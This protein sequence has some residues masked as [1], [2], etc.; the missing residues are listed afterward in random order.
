MESVTRQE[1][2]SFEGIMPEGTYLLVDDEWIKYDGSTSIRKLFYRAL[3]AQRVG[4]SSFYVYGYSDVI[5]RREPVR[6]VYTSK[7][8]TLELK[9]TAINDVPVSELPNVIILE[10]KE[11]KVTNKPA[12]PKQAFG[13]KKPD[14][15]LLPLSGQLAQWEAHKDGANKYGPFNWRINAVEANTYIN[16]ALRHLQLYAAGE[17]RARDTNVSNLGAVMACC[18][19]LID[20]EKHS[21]LIDNRYKSSVECDLLHQA[22]EMMIKLRKAQE[23]RD[24]SIMPGWTKFDGNVLNACDHAYIEIKYKDGSSPRRRK[25]TKYYI[26]WGE[27]EYWRPCN[28]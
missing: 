11:K 20:A 10:R 7:D 28:G 18:A 14:L 8:L 6:G 17:E 15:R 9:C 19:I 27:V 26:D 16:A 5:R 2:G 1:T 23:E 3:E 25:Y 21:K 13:D 4:A 24:K 22:E 12:N